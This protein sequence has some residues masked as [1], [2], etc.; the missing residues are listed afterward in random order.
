MRGASAKHEYSHVRMQ[1]ESRARVGI[2]G[3]SGYTGAELLRLLSAHPRAEVTV[4]TAERSAGKSIGDVYPQFAVGQYASKLPTLVKNDDVSDWPKHVDVVFCCL[5]HATTQEIIASLPLDRIRVVDLSADFRLRDVDIY[6]K[7]YGGEHKAPELQ[8]QAVYGLTE[9]NRDAIANARLVANPGCY[10][11]SA[12]LP[13]IPL[14][15]NSL[16]STQGIIIDAKSGT[17]GAGRSPKVGTLF[18]EVADGISAY[19]VASHRHSPEIEQGLSEAANGQQVTV[20][21]TPHLMPMSRGILET[22]YVR[23]NEGVTAADLHDCLANFY[24]EEAFVHVLP[25]GSPPPQTR[26]LRGSNN[27]V[28]QV[29]E[30]RVPGQAIIISAID[31]VVKGASGQAIQ[32]MNLMLDFPETLGLDGPPMFP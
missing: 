30:D 13:L 23:M 29:V 28:I 11:T 17:T 1:S 27:C 4:M 2:L 22:I 21:F 24:E 19:G 15:R 26:H 32:N 9:I 20:S 18:C 3:A 12:Q 25:K 5:P 16:I 6:K 8:K 7:W 14:I 31:N 10:P